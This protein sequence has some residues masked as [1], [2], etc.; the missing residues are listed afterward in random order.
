MGG[1]G[2]CVSFSCAWF[3]LASYAHKV[4]TQP[5]SSPIAKPRMIGLRNCT[6]RELKTT[7]NTAAKCKHFVKQLRQNGLDMK[8]Q[9]LL[10]LAGLL[11]GVTLSFSPVQ[12]QN[13]TSSQQ[14]TVY[15][16]RAAP[17]EV[18]T[19]QLA[20][21]ASSATIEFT[22]SDGSKISVQGTV[23]STKKKLTFTLPDL[24]GGPRT[25]Q[26]KG[27]EQTAP[28]TVL[29]ELEP[30][31]VMLVTDTSTVASQLPQKLKSLGLTVLQQGGQDLLPLGGSASGICAGN[32]ILAQLNG[33][34]LGTMLDSLQKLPGV[35]HADPVA[36]WYTNP[37]SLWATSKDSND[38]LPPEEIGRSYLPYVLPP[39]ERSTKRGE[40]SVIAILDTGVS[41]ITIQG[42]EQKAFNFYGTPVDLTKTGSVRGTLDDDKSTATEFGHGTLVAA[43]AAA[44]DPRIGVANA[45]KV[46]S[47]KVCDD[48]GMCRTD[49][50]L[51]G[52]CLAGQSVA[53]K[54]LVINMS[55]GGDTPMNSVAQ[56]L[57]DLTK[58]GISVVTSAGNVPP[59]PEPETRSRNHY[60]ASYGIPEVVVVGSAE[61]IP[62]TNPVQWRQA[63]FSRSLPSV[64]L[65]IPVPQIY[66]D[67][68][69]TLRLNSRGNSFSTGV[70]AG[71]TLIN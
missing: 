44:S 68:G 69:G 29:N 39:G 5:D 28:L 63:G 58:R 17:G 23:D 50:V 31:L 27:Q 62:G 14:L 47:I 9:S 46:Q 2:F 13:L 19:L 65:L 56:V 67:E 6:V 43:L 54:K 32:L 8:V 70:A 21:Q 25:V 7:E 48:K 55:F 24:L 34:P 4:E 18:V 60:P 53:Q 22:D 11:I 36:K 42:T 66:V 16:S 38:L 37:R 52:L 71:L 57:K 12:A 49:R 3:L 33:K 41:Q 15:P 10:T 30:G 61:P 51:R 20:K 59:R 40:G 64:T 1:L 35:V 26:A 45:A